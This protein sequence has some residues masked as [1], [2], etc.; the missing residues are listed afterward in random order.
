MIG[1]TI[2]NKDADTDSY[3]DVTGTGSVI[4]D[5]VKLDTTNLYTP[6]NGALVLSNTGV[7]YVKF[8][9][10]NGVSF[11][12]GTNLDYPAT[13]ESGTIRYNTDLG[14]S[15]VYDTSAGWIPISGQPLSAD[16]FTDVNNLWAL[17]L[18]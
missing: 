4:F 1:T 13:P 11:G 16:D 9:G 10:S 15:E 6:N 7:G 14:Y 18:G 12:T 17:I 2:S 3:L 5:D 8:N